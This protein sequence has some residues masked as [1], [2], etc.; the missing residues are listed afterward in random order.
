MKKKK[1][2]D[3]DNR[4]A[5]FNDIPGEVGDENKLLDDD[6]ASGEQLPEKTEHEMNDDGNESQ[7]INE[8]KGCG[9]E[10][11]GS[12][13]TDGNDIAVQMPDTAIKVRETGEKLIEVPGRADKILE[14]TFD[15]ELR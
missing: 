3:A 5:D 9:I 13:S 8:V 12:R 10:D 2:G 7:R 1:T 4:D 11:G 14:K 6:T 15:V